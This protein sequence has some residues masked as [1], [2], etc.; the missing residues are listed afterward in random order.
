MKGKR[1]DTLSVQN[2]KEDKIHYIHNIFLNYYFPF[3]VCL[4]KVKYRVNELQDCPSSKI[5]LDTS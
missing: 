5:I 1:D 2:T 3:D 4:D